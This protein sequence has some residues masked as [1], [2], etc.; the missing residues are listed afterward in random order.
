MKLYGGNACSTYDVRWIVE[1]YDIGGYIDLK[2]RTGWTSHP[3]YLIVPEDSSAALRLYCDLSN[4]ESCE[5]DLGNQPE[6]NRVTRKFIE[7]QDKECTAEQLENWLD[8]QC[9]DLDDDDDDQ[10]V[11]EFGVVAAGL[12]MIGALAGMAIFRKR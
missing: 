1:G 10:E 3:Q 12:A 8:G 2:G 6:L 5:G 9:D 4:T 11:P 7:P